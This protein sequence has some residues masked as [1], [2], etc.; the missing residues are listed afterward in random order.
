MP[1]TITS[2]DP[3]V[4]P[5]KG[6]ETYGEMEL[7]MFKV[8]KVGDE[9]RLRCRLDKVDSEGNAL[10]GE[11]FSVGIN[12]LKSQMAVTPK[13]AQ[14]WDTIVDVMGLAYDFYACR[15]KVEEVLAEGG[16]PTEAI[17]ARASALAALRAP[18]E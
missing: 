9:L 15:D 18:V 1:R 6:E 14:A 10:R 5:A 16:D 3:T 13:F 4:V 12:D 8:T 2:I 17:A 7:S 11:D